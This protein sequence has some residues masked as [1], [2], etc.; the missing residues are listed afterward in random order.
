VGTLDGANVEIREEAGEENFF[1]FGLDSDEVQA[2]RAGYKPNKY[3]DENDE[4]KRIMDQLGRGF[5]SAENPTLFQPVL[6]SLRND[7]HYCVLADYAG[8]IACQETISRA[9]QDR[10]GWTRKAIINVARSGKFSSDRAVE[11]YARHI[12]GAGPLDMDGRG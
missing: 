8:Y 1:R 10:A 9:Y 5:F 3:I 2:V 4:L 7:D 12:W 11:E 6:D